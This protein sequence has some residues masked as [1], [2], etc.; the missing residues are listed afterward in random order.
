MSG[1]KFNHGD[2][3]LVT[4]GQLAGIVGS[5]VGYNINITMR[6]KHYI[7]LALALIIAMT[8]CLYGAIFGDFSLCMKICLGF[9]SAIL[10]VLINLI[11]YFMMRR[12]NAV[13]SLHSY[14]KAYI[15][16]IIMKD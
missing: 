4:K 12:K 8:V 16:Q 13:L 6:R 10:N 2:Q 9:A 5:C 7:I 14:L 3:L 1:K 15:N 11:P